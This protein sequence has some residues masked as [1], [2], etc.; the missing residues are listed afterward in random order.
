[1]WQDILLVLGAYFLGA[2]PHLY[3]LAK[4]RR[5]GLEGDYHQ[6]LWYRAG[7]VFGVI[8][9]VGEFV[10]G[11]VP[12]LVARLLDF[13]PTTI[14][15]TGVA[16]VCG[17]M[18]PVFSRFDGEKG[19]SI[20]V[21]V[22]FALSPLASLVAVVPI[23]IS[24]IVRFTPRVIVKVRAG[25]DKPIIGGP[26]SMSLPLGMAGCFMVLPVMAWHFHEPMAT[27]WGF[28]ALFILIILR[29]LTAGLR[30]DLK[31]D[32]AIRHILVRRLLY[33]RATVEWRNTDKTG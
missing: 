12:V 33:D 30:A 26:Y 22:A 32:T 20:G 10:K 21:A 23:I 6:E 5:V 13:N 24:L 7:R 3:F 9:V 8:G 25:S 27:V 31:T 28:V 17:Q 1:M 18:W 4:L 2:V 14:A 29:R 11:I 19:N 15:I 16:A